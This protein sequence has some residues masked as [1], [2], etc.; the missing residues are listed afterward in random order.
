MLFVRDGDEWR[1]GHVEIDNGWG[2][3]GLV[4]VLT[5]RTHSGVLTH[6]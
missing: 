6:P 2:A 1:G 5:P 3:Q 4:S